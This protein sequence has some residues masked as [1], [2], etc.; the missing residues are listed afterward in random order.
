MAASLWIGGRGAGPL[1]AVGPLLDPFRGVWATARTAELPSS[2]L[3]RIPNLS[4]PVEVR[5]DGR[6]VPH[7]FAATEADAVRALGF[8]VARDR[9]FQLETQTRA[10]TGRLSE[11]AGAPAIDSD[12]E[13]RALGLPRSA[14]RRYAALASDSRD[15]QVFDAY[16][17]G[18]NAWIDGLSPAEWP[19]EY[20]LLGARPERWRPVNSLHL[21]SR[22]GWTLAWDR[23][24]RSRLAAA[25]RV[26]MEAAKALFPVHSPVQEPIQPNGTNVPR[27]D[28]GPIPPPGAPD[29]L[30]GGIAALWPHRG[31]TAADEA[32]IFASNNWAVA[33]ERTARGFALLAGDPH[34]ELTLPSIWYEAHLVVPG[35][36]DVY[37]VTIPGA[38]GIII[39]F[40]REVA[41]SFTNTGADVLDYYRETVDDTASPTRYRVDGEWREV[42]RVVETYRGRGGRELRVD[43]TYYTHRGPLRRSGSDW[44]SMRWTVLEASLH[45]AV[46]LDAARAT[47]ARAFL[48]VMADGWGAP[49][50]NMIAADRGGTIAI[51]STGHFPLRPAGTDG[52]TIF[53]G[54]ST[55]NDWAGFWPLER[56]PQAVDPPQGYLASANQEPLDPREGA[57]YLGHDSGFEAWRAL[58]INNLLRLMPAVTAQEMRRLQTDPGSAR[59]DLFVPF[60]HEAVQTVRWRGGGSLGLEGAANLLAEWDRR[61]TKENERAVLFEAAMRQLTPRVWDELIGPDGRRVATPSAAVLLQL[62]HDPHNAWWDDDRTPERVEDRDDILTASLVAAYDSLLVRYG[63]A[64][65]GGWRWDRVMPAR[66]THLLGLEP[67]S[68]TAVPAQG[69]PGTL[70]PVSGGGFGA[71]WRMVVEIGPD[72]RAWATYPGGQSGNPFSSRYLD[73]LPRWRDGELDSLRTPRDTAAIPAGDLTA[74]LSLMPGG[75]P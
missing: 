68:A 72:V 63:P 43:T 74:R 53:D 44:L 51:R 9:L 1:P 37:G 69:G 52:L 6:G 67:F 8:V 46:F 24:E 25:S 17:D 47:T 21:F 18:V 28:F 36:L 73:R 31:P 55:A 5:Y 13:V 11:W 60:F 61:Y 57:P 71:S 34:L 4:A 39:G 38:P 30:A 3:A 41:W 70:N 54:S 35:A 7:I 33:P 32:P 50:Q 20:K 62:L 45:G 58:R 49:A 12:R 29:T 2:A 42:E 23:G 59:A 15:K 66:V 48:D 65:R 16:A 27:F 75:A 56:Y 10:A 14:E 22:M 19:I 64:D 40:T 26:G